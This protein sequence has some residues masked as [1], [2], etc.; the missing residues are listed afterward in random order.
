MHISC[1]HF[2][3]GLLLIVGTSIG[4][5]MLALPIATASTGFLPSVF[6]LIFC[7]LVMTAGA[8]LVLE[9]NLRLPEG[10]NMISMARE[11]LGW[12]GQIIAWITYLFLF[13]TLLAAYI[14]GGGDVLN[15]ILDKFQIHLSDSLTS[16][17]FTLC[18]SLVVYGGVR[19]VDYVNRGLMFGK[20]GIYS[21]LVV[22]ISPHI[23]SINLQGGI[24]ETI[25][26][27]I[28][29]LIASFGF[30]SLVPVLRV[31]FKGNV[32]VLRKLILIGSLIPLVC[33]ILWNAVIMG[34]VSAEGENGLASLTWSEH[35]ISG[36]ANALSSAVNNAWIMVFF[37]IFTSICMLTAFLG[38]SLGLSDFL[39]DGLHLQKAGY[40]GKC[41]LLLTFIPPLLLVLINP[42]IYL[43]AMNY[44]GICCVILLLLLPASMAWRSRTNPGK[45][46]PVANLVPGGYISLI[47]ITGVALAL[48]LITL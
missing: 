15:G 18:F 26:Q 1:S 47:L 16:F 22:I 28:M 17:L 21:L 4:G 48:L 35:A 32:V 20:L 3:G 42:G 33:Y 24:P 8:L 10:S 23:S 12:P 45:L 9:V 44:A 13:Y 39:S 14:S 46:F 29:I 6:F 37:D 41:T 30:A 25:T 27:S 31:Y 40:Q 5:G 11:T 19:S 7:W 38:V 36:L 34:T 43:L 2:I